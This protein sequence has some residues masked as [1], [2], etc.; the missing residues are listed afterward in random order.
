MR[1]D[2]SKEF[3]LAKAKKEGDSAVGVVPPENAVYLRRGDW[4]DWLGREVRRVWIEWAREQTNPKPSWLMPW[5]ELVETDREVDR[6]IGEVLFAYG[7]RAAT[8]TATTTPI[9][10]H[11]C[12]SCGEEV[13]TVNECQKSKRP[14]G[15]HCNHSWSQDECCWC[16]KTFEGEGNE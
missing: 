10:D 6:R 3:W 11:D 16:G 1:L 7:A 12:S 13:P 5:E 15:H 14:C 4:R 2:R 8:A 9:E